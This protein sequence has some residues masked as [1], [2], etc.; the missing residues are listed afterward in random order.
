[1]VG[2]FS[3]TNFFAG[4]E[5]GTT[6][7]WVMSLALGVGGFLCWW[8]GKWFSRGP[9]VSK[10]NEPPVRLK[11]SHTIFFIPM[12]WIGIIA[13]LFAIFASIISIREFGLNAWIH[14]KNKFIAPE[15]HHPNIPIAPPTH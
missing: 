15:F 12:H 4:K 6:H 7:E 3:A 9:L 14:G 5:Y 13:I 8:I 1:M 2:V 10:I 11:S